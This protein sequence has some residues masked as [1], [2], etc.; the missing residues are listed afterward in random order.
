MYAQTDP[1]R[2]DARLPP[3]QAA[4]D[5]ETKHG[6]FL[7]GQGKWESRVKAPLGE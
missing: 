7:I 3:E 1:P 6:S 4:C 2:G 5:Q